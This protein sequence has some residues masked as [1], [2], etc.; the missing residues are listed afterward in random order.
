MPGLTA[1]LR[2][3]PLSRTGG[4]KGAAA[5]LVAVLLAGGVLLGMTAL[6]VDVGSLYAEREELMSGADAAAM[7][8]ALD[9]ALDR[10]ECKTDLAGDGPARETAVRYAQENARDGA[11]D[12]IVCGNDPRLRDCDDP[13]FEP[14]GNLTDCLGER[15]DNGTR[16]VEVRTTTLLP[17]GST[18]LPP[19]FAQ[20]LVAGYQGAEVGA[21]ARV[22]W[23]S[24]GAGLAVT[25]STCE[26]DEAT[27]KGEDFAPLPPAVPDLTY[28]TVLRL[29]DSQGSSTCAAGPS[30]WDAPGGF[31]WLDENGG[32]CQTE[33]A[34]DEYGGEVG[35]NVPPECADA[36]EDA[37]EDR[38][39]L[40]MP[41][42]DGIA[43]EGQN[44][45][46]HL[47]GFAAFVVTGYF[48]SPGN[49]TGPGSVT[50]ESSLTGDHYCGGQERC[51]YGYFTATLIPGQGPVGPLPGNFGA[52]VVKTIG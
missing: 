50:A 29:H 10:T 35:N 26:W 7:A 13:D 15:P 33:V 2:R 1:R 43:G 25:I 23:G 31:G 51:I 9:C 3:R 32:P 11:A 44:T 40:L 46:Y 47:A 5:T 36:L 42:F 6:V 34:D 45:T 14:V 24:P 4:D 16:Y 21:C 48:L 27:N 37:R 18:L 39:V 22:A 20:T 19:S 17:G 38:T 28:E 41:V 49:P 12:A 52:M 30:G 8:I